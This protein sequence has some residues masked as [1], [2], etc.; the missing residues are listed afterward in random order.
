M[1]EK[2][3]CAP[4]VYIQHDTKEFKIVIELAG[5]NKQDINLE[6]T[7][8]GFCLNGQEKIVTLAGVTPLLTK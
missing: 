6:M 4:V 2:L 1:I 7:D 3:W 5:V 8:S